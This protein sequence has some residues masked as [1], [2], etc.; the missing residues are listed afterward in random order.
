MTNPEQIGNVVDEIASEFGRIDCMINNAGWHP[1]AQTIH[2][3]SIDDFEYILH[4][5]LT[6]TFAGCK[7]AL[8]HLERTKG[9]IIN[10]ASMVGLLGQADATSYCAPK[11]GQI[12]LTKALAVDCPSKGVRVNAVCPAGVDTPLIHEWAGTLNEKTALPI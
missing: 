2:D 4:L 12:G 10:M 11:A 7:Y 8:P 6:S 9:T 1:P 5:N 3:I